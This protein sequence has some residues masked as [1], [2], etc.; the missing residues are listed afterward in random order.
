MAAMTTSWSERVRAGETLVLDG[1]VGTELRRRGVALDAAAWS[2]PAS[3]AHADALR[4]IHADYIAAGADVVTTN[5]FAS[6]RFV[7]ASAGLEARFEA[8]NR[9]AVAAAA[10][11]RAASGRPVAIAGSISCLPPRFEVGAY[12]RAADER[13]AYRELGVLLVD[14]GVDLLALEMLEDEEHAARACEA[15]M[16]L[17]VPVWVGVSC[18]LDGGRL[19]AYDFPE[20]A[21]DAVLSAVLPFRP[22]AVNVMHSPLAAIAPALRAVRARWD[23]VAGAY[24][25]IDAAVSPLALASAAREWIAAGA[26]IVGGCCGS[27]PAHIA[28]VAHD[29][30]SVSG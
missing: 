8:L 7:L 16:D 21:L 30:A 10:D 3:L 23:G 22:A 28:R 6:T 2:G 1:G 11:A 17:G 14:A 5:T 4:A 27:T 24:P 29:V 12:P 9:S 18:R 25:E 19:V 13:A 15:V 20:T 26:R